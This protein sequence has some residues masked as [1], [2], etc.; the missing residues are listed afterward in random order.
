MN[1]PRKEYIVQCIISVLGIPRNDFRSNTASN[2]SLEKFLD[3]P[4][5]TLLQA[6]ENGAGGDQAKRTVTLSTSLQGPEG[7]KEMHFVKLSAEPL[8]E[9]NIDTIVMVSSLR[10]AP[11]SLTSDPR[12]EYI[13]NCIS[14]V[15]GIQRGEFSM[16]DPNC[17]A[18]LDKFLDDPNE[19]VLQAIANP[20]TEGTPGRP[21]LFFSGVR[22]YVDGCCEVHFVKMTYEP[23]TLENM[24]QSVMV[25]SMR[26]S[27]LRSLFFNVKEVFMPALVESSGKAES[28]EGR[29]ADC[30]TELDAGLNASFR[31]GLR[32]QQHFDE[33]DVSG[34][35]SPVDEVRFWDDMKSASGVS[36]SQTDR[37]TKFSEALAPVANE[38]DDLNKKS[39]AQLLD[40]ADTLMDALDVLWQSDIEPPYPEQRM[41]HFLGV[42]AGSFGRTVQAKLNGLQ[43]WTSAFSQVSKHIREGHKVCE[44]WN[45]LCADF[46]GTQ[47]KTAENEWRGD[48]FKSMFLA[49]L[50]QR[51]QEVSQV[52]SQHDQILKLLSE[53]ELQMLQVEG[54]FAPFTKLAVFSYNDYTV[55]IWRAALSEYEMRMVPVETRVAERLRAELFTQ[56][57]NPAQTV[58]VF[59]RYQDL[60]ERKNIRE[61][62]T[63][64]R[65]RLMTE[66]GDF[67]ERI[68]HELDTFDA[69][70]LPAGRGLSVHTRKIM[71]VEQLRSKADLAARPLAGFLR[72]LHSAGKLSSTVKKVRQ[73]L[74]ETRAKIFKD[75]QDEV[76]SQLKD[77]D[78]PIALELNSRVMD[79]DS[80][81]QGALKITYSERLIMLVKE[82]RVFEQMGCTIPKL[83]KGA[84]DNGLKFYR[85]AVQLK[86]IC[87]FYNHLSAELLPSQRLMVLQPALA[88]EALFSDKQSNMKK[89]LWAKLD[90]L[91]A[92]TRNVKDG[93]ERLRSV[94]RRLRNGHSQVA[95]EVVTLAN[96]SLLRQR[97]Q[98]KTKLAQIQ[99]VIDATVQACSCQPQDS[100]PWKAHWDHQIF[101]I[102]EIQYR[103]G[104]ESLNENLSE[105]KADLVLA[106]KQL[107]LK[108]PIEELKTAYYKEIRSFISLPL[109]FKGLDGA[110]HIY[111]TML[112]RNQQG[113]AVVFQKAED[114]FQKVQQLQNSFA[115]WLVIGLMPERM[116]E[117]VD[118][119]VDPR[120]W[121]SNFKALKQKRKDM[122][123]I[124]DTIRID[125]VTISTVVLKSV[126]EEHLERLSDVLVI[127]LKRKLTE[128]YKKVMSFLEDALE[129]L[130][131]RPDSVQELGKAQAD[132]AALLEQQPE[133]SKMM[134]A[135]DEKNKMLRTV[136]AGVELGDMHQK[137]EEFQL[138]LEAFEQLAN[139]LREELKGK[140]DQRIQ[141]MNAE[142]EK[143]ASR[144]QSLK[145]K[146]ATDCSIDEARKNA[147]AM[148]EW[149]GEWEGLKEQIETLKGDCADF[150]LPE[151]S[152]VDMAAV[153]DDLNKQAQSWALF[154]EYTMQLEE[155]MSQTWLEFRPRL[156]TIQDLTT[157]WLTKLKDVPRD[158]VTHLLAQQV[159]RMGTAY[160]G[161]KAMTGEP[162]ERDHWKILFGLLKM[163]NDTKLET[164]TFRMVVERLDIVVEKVDDIKE[165]T[166][167]A[168]GEVN[169][170]DAVMEVAAWFEQTEFS[171][172]DHQ[173]KGGTVP[174]IKDWKDLLSSVSDMQNLCG[175][176]KDSRYFPPFK[177][178]VDKFQE[179]L[180][181]MD[182]LLIQM[183]KVQRK[184]VYLEP[185]FGRGAL[186]RE[187]ERF[188][189]VNGQYR[190]IMKS[191]GSAKKVNHLCSVRGLKEQLST[192][193]DQLERCQKALN[194]F[195]EEKRSA[196]P[197][198]YFIGDEDLL[199]ILGQSSN[200]EVIQAH[201]KKLFAGIA[202]V[203]FDEGITQITRMKS[204][205]KEV[206]T[207]SQPVVV[208]ERDE[209]RPVEEWLADLA[210]EMFVSLAGQ[211]QKCYGQQEFN[212]EK[213]EQFPS[214]IL[215]LSANLHFTQNIEKYMQSGQLLQL[216]GDLQQQL[217]SLTSLSMDGA[218][219]Q[220]KLKSLIL[221]LIHNISVLD[222]LLQNKVQKLTDWNWFK[223]L[224][225]YIKVNCPPEQ[226]PCSVRMLECE[227]NYSFEYQG[228]APKLVHTPLTDKCYLTLMHGMHLGYGGNPYG[229]AGTGKTES[230]KALGACLGRQVLVFNCD[231][232]IDFQ[233][234]G[235]IFVGLV[236]CGA[237]GCFDEFNRLLEEQ[238]S[239][240]SQSVQLIQA[241][242][243]NVAKTVALMG[244][245]VQVNHNA[246]IFIT[247]NPATKGYGGRQKLPDNLKQ[248]F[249][250]VAMSVPDNELI[251]EVMMFSEGF[252]SAKILAQ[253]VVA[254]FLLSRQLLSSQQ[255]YDWGLRA[256]KPI[257]TLAGRLLQ[258]SKVERAG[259]DQ[260]LSDVEESV[261]LLKAVRMNTLSK[262][263]FADSRRFQDLCV[264]LFPGVNV[265]D[266]EYKE[267]EVAI[268]ESMKELKLSEIDS[269]ISKMLQFHEACQQRM[270]V[271][272]VGPSGCGKSTIWRVLDHAYK[273]QG[274]KYMVHVMN[275][276]SMPRVRLLGHMDPDTRE[277]FDGVLTASARKV[278][279]EPSTTHNW[280]VCD[281]DIDPEWVESLNSVLDD[282]RLLTM[283]NGER[284]QFGTN[285][286]FIFET[287]NLRFA[288]PATISR[289]TMIFLSEED[290]DVPW[291]HAQPEAIIARLEQWF[292]ELFYRR[293]Q[294][295]A[296]H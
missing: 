213:F 47:W 73:E 160:P 38:L 53:E 168:I 239:A 16:P 208:K 159:Q 123:K 283:P 18:I 138:R 200:P 201:L 62:L 264:D 245:E 191:I 206:V 259:Q 225:Y 237:W 25:S 78:D 193:H 59:Q 118:A 158:S 195:L 211:L 242:I 262:L 234:M 146:T 33:K 15:L 161:L 250:P 5:E 288:S 186:P 32:K 277:W 218:L 24:P 172:L 292:D 178:Q 157:E 72:D 241:A 167:R 67:V 84:V 144:W 90:Q 21:L 295:R 69:N 251:A 83:V 128:D 184:W 111:K 88:F 258:E 220:A 285:V 165:L 257:L 109:S 58:R 133:V 268:R 77:G 197:R 190:Q 215:C 188:D 224:R 171:F 107:K 102:M 117:L 231:E 263:T 43:V 23:L 50:A 142:I 52:R 181:L 164:L 31:R 274:K 36:D 48:M 255:H 166:S 39:F 253:K 243:K 136:S 70:N 261:L 248:L 9:A 156:F 173:V 265:K 254:L 289:L 152:L 192:I 287:D 98:W 1:D 185:I 182:E 290:V 20:P 61:A 209:P 89:V 12:A 227:L 120:E 129:K 189:K 279:K 202:N 2:A 296:G 86:Q 7:N 232:G 177:D 249:R 92:F 75:W 154:E 196:F 87:N 226:K 124:P 71:W 271:G 106:N 56:T 6:I 10:Q 207:L 112:D 141:N 293:F 55:P 275:P 187:K 57:S 244:R 26:M 76:Q 150:G 100:K 260:P 28:L 65:E 284:I 42:I 37:A 35:I 229:P 199:E 108:P 99:K 238:M 162:Y 17:K 137:Y 30:L 68:L 4:N 281:G 203:D 278:I 140:M 214:Q 252:M 131:V 91:E 286:N 204:S 63:N 115:P 104:L 272:I 54:C 210:L 19:K 96:I 291:I 212:M 256:L 223:Q 66:L 145:P 233:A 81:Q 240:I 236:R 126:V 116:Q 11:V 60:L 169:I 222:E 151:P 95:S 194:T 149:Q 294:I 180:A 3:D 219:E 122:D 110:A 94:N 247:L 105:M 183:N 101:K 266:I 230:V 103:F 282:N 51:I 155:M 235:R 267:L 153:E 135:A 134:A 44:K 205:L 113:V 148:Q 27:A 22:S 127:A 198:L 216:K 13:M 80:S 8:T 34:I 29:L 125:C 46:T 74:K 85:F 41:Q 139:E 280:I 79:F 147:A 174:L 175:S 269:Q 64:E 276:K 14:S 163:P 217:T 270:G 40:F 93:A 45:E 170:R 176:L 221:D 179:K 132:A 130:N 97:D 246:G 119:M 273:K 114:L 82:A 49:N 228:N 121:D 143:F